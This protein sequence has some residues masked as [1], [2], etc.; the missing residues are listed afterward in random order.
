MVALTLIDNLLLVGVKS[1]QCPVSQC[2]SHSARS[3][4]RI[5]R[6]QSVND[7][8]ITQRLYVDER[9]V[10]QQSFTDCHVALMFRRAKSSN[11]RQWS[12][13]LSTT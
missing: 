8:R 13:S 2:F 5:Q 6:D 9:A 1:N 12:K 11:A 10:R 3:R 7:V 4:W